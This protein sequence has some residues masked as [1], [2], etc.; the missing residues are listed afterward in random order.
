[1]TVSLNRKLR[2]AIPFFFITFIKWFM[3]LIEILFGKSDD[4]GIFRLFCDLAWKAETKTL[5][6]KF[7]Y[8]LRAQCKKER[9]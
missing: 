6:L 4:S 3:Q 8:V 1:M 7:S 9:R 2:N 5:R